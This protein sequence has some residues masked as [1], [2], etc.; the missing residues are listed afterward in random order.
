MSSTNV[1]SSRF[2]DENLSVASLIFYEPGFWEFPQRKFMSLHLHKVEGDLAG[3]DP[4]GFVLADSLAKMSGADN[5]GSTSYEDILPK[6]PPRAARLS[7]EEYNRTFSLNKVVDRQVGEEVKRQLQDATDT[8]VAEQSN[9]IIHNNCREERSNDSGSFDTNIESSMTVT[10]LDSDEKQGSDSLDC[11]LYETD[12]PREVERLS[13]ECCRL[14]ELLQQ[15]V[16]NLERL[17][18]LAWHGSPKDYRG[19]I[20]KILLGYWPIVN[21]RRN[22]VV[23]RKREDYRVSL[24]RAFS[25]S[26][27]S[28]TE[29]ERLVW[30]QITLDVPR[31]CSDYNLFRL[32]ALQELL[33]RILFVWSVRHP[34][35]GYVQGMNDILMPLVYVLFS[36]VYQTR[37]STFR[38]TFTVETE[39]FSSASIQ[40]VEKDGVLN[41]ED[42]DELNTALDDLEADVYWCFS[43]VLESIQ[44]FYTFAQPGIQRRI[45]LLERL[46]GR[47]CP[48]LY[49]H[50]QRQG[51]ELVQFAFRWFNCLLIRELPFPVVI[52]LWDSVL[53]EEDG[54]GSFYVF[55]CASLLHFF[56][57]DLI[58]MEFQDLIL[59]LQN[60]PKDIWTDSNVKILLS[61]A[62]LWREIFISSKSSLAD[63]I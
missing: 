38:P 23:K 26:R 47:V 46:L 6:V 8:R 15:S 58:R 36:E 57:K 11:A 35:C 17:K 48:N 12:I 20:W 60:I 3:E 19:T 27:K 9:R 31:I 22:E 1:D 52:R 2:E 42:I 44:D 30:R 49:G 43:S 50:F 53:C 61:Q 41:L 28:E 33:K 16:I 24:S 25:Q 21:L 63:R 5:V 62:Y 37:T 14:K 55:I 56:E 7:F 51:V 34:A 29:Q 39:S 45:Q 13:P 40:Y 10:E 59:F 4:Y 32:P 18:Q 54:F